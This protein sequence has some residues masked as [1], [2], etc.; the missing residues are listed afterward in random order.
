MQRHQPPVVIGEAEGTTMDTDDIRRRAE[1]S[2]L[3]KLAAAFPDDLAKAL[4]NGKALVDR[5]PSDLH[6]TEEPAHTFS[7][8]G[9]RER[10]S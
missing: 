8:A 1:A 5:L 7:L 10:K 2:G 4:A 6:W 3:Q 9:K